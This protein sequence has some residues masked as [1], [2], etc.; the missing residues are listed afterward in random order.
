MQF[1]TLQQWLGWLEQCHPTEIEL[2]LERIR[3]VA[4]RLD[5]L[6][7]GARV[8]TVAGTNGKGSCVTATAALLREAGLSVGVYTSPH[9]LQYNERIVI[10]GIAASDSEIC[11]AFAR[12]FNVCGSISLTYFEFGT[13]AALDIFRRHQLDVV[14]LEVGLGGRLDAVNIL[15]ADVAVITSI[16]LDHQ[17]WL[18][19]DREAIGAEKAGIM[20]CGR[21]AVC[22][23]ANPPASVLAWCETVG[24][25][26]YALNQN[27]DFSVDTDTW[28]WWGKDA[29]GKIHES[30]SMPLPHL[31]LPSL[32][33]ALQAVMLL[34][35]DLS[36]LPFANCLA[37]LE[38]PG[39][40]QKL[41]F[42]GREVILDVAHNPAASAY[43]SQRLRNSPCSGRTFAVVGMMADK[44]IINSLRNLDSEIDSWYLAHLPAI[45]RAAS[46]DQ[47]ARSLAV[48]D[49]TAEGQGT[50]TECLTQ[51]SKQM[52][53]TDRIV[54]WGSFY[55]VAAA[56]AAL[57]SPQ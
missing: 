1:T 31:P 9:L 29:M 57:Q 12:I 38:M 39:R 45:P 13:L 3:Q 34:G 15:D 32:A 17:E 53:T 5:L 8:I 22:A 27:F 43:L 28:C 11:A 14:V 55:T 6:T 33:A 51:L 40:F 18:G 44:D 37:T 52:G 42:N 20:R 24:A 50:I 26:W 36:S 49:R 56:L 21:P 47:L 10:N 16:D 4:K 46:V 30:G 41:S 2:G 48:L 35:V 54:I 23:D 19:A 25:S 7:P